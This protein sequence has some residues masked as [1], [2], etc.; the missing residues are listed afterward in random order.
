VSWAFAFEVRYATHA[1][2]IE[3]AL[4]AALYLD[5]ESERLRHT[6]PAQR[7]RAVERFSRANPFRRA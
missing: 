4:G 7:Q 5:P 3:R 1:D 6:S 2:D